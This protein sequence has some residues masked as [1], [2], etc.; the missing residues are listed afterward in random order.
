M[1]KFIKAEEFKRKLIDEKNFFP[2]IVAR[3]L[4]DMSSADV[5][6]VVRCKDCIYNV[7]NQEVDPLDSTDYSGDNI[8]CSFFMTDGLED[9]DF[10]SC[11]ERINEDG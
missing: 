8:V 10:C 1:D 2:T 5:E 11:G 7:A 6:E 3:A 9:R 4:E